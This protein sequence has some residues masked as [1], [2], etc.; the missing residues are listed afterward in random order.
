MV[1]Q[2]ARAYRGRT[3]ELRS[4]WSV[5]IEGMGT[6]SIPGSRLGPIPVLITAIL[7]TI[8]TRSVSGN[9]FSGNSQ[10]RVDDCWTRYNNALQGMGEL[11]IH[12]LD[13]RLSCIALRTYLMC[14]RHV[15]NMTDSCVGDI[16][17]H[18]VQK[19]VESRM[20]HNNCSMQGEIYTGS[21]TNLGPGYERPQVPRARICSYKPQKALKTVHRHCGLFGDPHLRTFGDEFQTCKVR[22]AWPLIDNEHLTVQ[23]TN[24]P[25]GRA[26]SATA[27]SKLTVVIKRNDDCGSDRF[28]TY[29][30]Q[31]DYL[32]STFD[33]GRDYFGQDKSV[34]LTVIETGKHVEI[35]IRY[36]A[37]TL[38]VRQVGH[39]FTF[40]IKMPEEII[41]KSREIPYALQLCV[42]GCPKSE[43]IDYKEFLS[44]KN[45][46]LKNIIHQKQLAMTREDAVAHCR[47]SQVVD[48]YFDSCVFDLM[49]TGDKNFTLAANK[50]LQDVLRLYPE[51]SKGH[52]NR[53]DLSTYDSYS[54]VDSLRTSWLASPLAFC[55]LCTLI[56]T[57]WRTL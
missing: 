49:T 41:N 18:S 55:V 7:F 39:Y 37:T 33:N 34:Q 11:Y 17:F 42:K 53:T 30:A 50:A 26:G 10:C 44:Q 8:I 32:P 13:Q 56:L 52:K 22:G 28:L 54:G 9:Q 3:P 16:R 24:D 29:Q 46:R 40:A 2:Q 23:V 47:Q 15:K 19:V 12:D 36:I 27:T 57:N 5:W 51:A 48:F 4:L 14:I 45:S 6:R 20:K 38:L 43:R 35:Y 31:T 1:G 25:V 21:D